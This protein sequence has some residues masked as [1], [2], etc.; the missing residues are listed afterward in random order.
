[1]RSK[2]GGGSQVKVDE[3]RFKFTTDF[4]GPLNLVIILLI[5]KEG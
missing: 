2:V 1:M 4:N 5:S 3:L